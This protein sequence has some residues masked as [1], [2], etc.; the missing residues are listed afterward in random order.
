MHHGKKASKW[1]HSEAFNDLL[2]RNM[3]LMFV[4]APSGV[5]LKTVLT[6]KTNKYLLLS[7]LCYDALSSQCES[8]ALAADRKKAGNT[9]NYF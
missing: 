3:L 6:V 4:T 8:T 2:L 5:S 1:L 9:H 7:K